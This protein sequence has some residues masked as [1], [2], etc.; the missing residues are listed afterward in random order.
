MF[1]NYTRKRVTSQV[2]RPHFISQELFLISL[3]SANFKQKI[4]NVHPLLYMVLLS[5]QRISIHCKVLTP[6]TRVAYRDC[7]DKII[8]SAEP[9]P[10]VDI[11]NGSW[12]LN[13]G[14]A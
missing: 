1:S 8:L 2:I 5:M 3:I 14:H 9:K 10:T 13:Y 11:Q 4:I 12:H 7:E 6:L